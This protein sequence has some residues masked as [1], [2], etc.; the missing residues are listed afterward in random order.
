MDVNITSE[1]CYGRI[2]QYVRLPDYLA[3]K[4]RATPTNSVGLKVMEMRTKHTLRTPSISIPLQ[5]CGAS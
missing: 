5:S 4:T 2:N 3:C 1:V